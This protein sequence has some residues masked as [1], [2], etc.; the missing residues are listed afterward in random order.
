MAEKTNSYRKEE[1]FYKESVGNFYLKAYRVQTISSSGSI[2]IAASPAPYFPFFFFWRLS[3]MISGANNCNSILWSMLNKKVIIESDAE[4]LEGTLIHYERSKG[5]EPFALLLKV[6]SRVLICKSWRSIR[7][8]SSAHT[9]ESKLT[10]FHGHKCTLKHAKR[11]RHRFSAAALE[12]K[13]CEK[14]FHERGAF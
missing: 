1:L 6:D 2:N 12:N 7:L 14:N 13:Y 10:R 9:T 4:Q 8:N 3:A 11:K 5:C